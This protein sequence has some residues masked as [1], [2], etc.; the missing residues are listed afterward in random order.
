MW[1]ATRGAAAFW[2][3]HR[4]GCWHTALSISLTELFK[5]S[6]LIVTQHAEKEPAFTFCPPPHPRIRFARLRSPASSAEADVIVFTPFSK[7]CKVNGG[8]GKSAWEGGVLCF[9]FFSSLFFFFYDWT[10]SLWLQILLPFPLLLVNVMTR[11]W[12]TS[13]LHWISSHSEG[14]MAKG[15]PGYLNINDSGAFSC[16]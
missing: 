10:A 5:V 4:Q 6:L 7:N 15:F 14:T 8:K 3:C 9:R 12:Q 13:N 2:E 16:Q 11:V 1:P